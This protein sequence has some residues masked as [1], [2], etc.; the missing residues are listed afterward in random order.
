LV[1]ITNAF[2]TPAFPQEQR[3]WVLEENL[4]FPR[5]YAA[6]LRG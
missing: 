2:F 6:R 4:K 5:R 3:T 1:L